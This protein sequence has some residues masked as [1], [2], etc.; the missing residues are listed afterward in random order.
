MSRFVSERRFVDL[1]K[2][3]WVF[4]LIRQFVV[5][6]L[7]KARSRTRMDDVCVAGSAWE[8]GLGE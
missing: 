7:K 6:E 1:V 4:G 2:G 5:V 8:R 3:H